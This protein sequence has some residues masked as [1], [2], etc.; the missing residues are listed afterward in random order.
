MV[1]SDDEER[2]IWF[3]HCEESPTPHGFKIIQNYVN[4]ADVIVGHNLKHDMDILRYYKVSFELKILHCTQLTDYLL[5]GQNTHEFN[6]D[7]NSVAARYSV[8]G[9]DN[10]V[11]TYW[12]SDI[13]TYDI[14][15]SLLGQYVLQDCRVPMVLY[16]HQMAVAE[17]ENMLKLIDLQ[18]EYQFT[19]CDMEVNGFVFSPERAREIITEYTKKAEPLVE[20][21]KE[22]VG[23]PHLNISSNTQ[24]SA[25]LYGGLLKT[26]WKEWTIKTYKTVPES[27]YWEKVFKEEKQIEGLKF[28][29]L[30]RSKR[31]DGYYKT[32]KETIPQLRARNETQKRAKKVLLEY[33]AVAKVIE[34]LQGKKK[35]KGLL[36]RVRSD[37]K[38]HPKLNA[39]VARTGRLTSPEQQWP[40]TGTSPIRECIVPK[41][42]GIMEIDLK[43]IE[44]NVAAELSEDWTMINEVNSGVDQH[45]ASCK[46]IMKMKLTPENRQEGKVF[47]YRYIYGGSV[48]GYFLDPNMPNFTYKRWKEI[49]DVANRKYYGLVDWQ[50]KNISTVWNS[51]GNLQVKTGRKFKFHKYE[52]KLMEWIYNENQIKNY[53]VQGVAGGDCFPLFAV[54]F[55]RGM[56]MNQLQSELILTAH[57]CLVIDYVKDELKF[58]VRLGGR[59]ANNLHVYMRN[60]FKI[61]WHTHLAGEIKIGP[62]YGQLKEITE[63]EI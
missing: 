36:S 44:W 27:K 42:D 14:P 24:L 2:V 46:D 13:D 40:R 41:H 19:L 8:P 57:D 9:K 30:A 18:N 34:T 60:Y 10:R 4:W 22:I 48:W 37:G 38:I 28:T 29:P 61:A 55:R 50:N 31:K 20:E 51:R 15:A 54:V 45:N 25:I 5:T 11:Q 39:T 43:T 56:M 59:I 47:N 49:L 1:T 7:L 3:D 53:P 26:T 6:F 33:S 52:D 35:D 16:P 21:I 58:L 12:D 17:R 23:E 62:N 63:D 32:D